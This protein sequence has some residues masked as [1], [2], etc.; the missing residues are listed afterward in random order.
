MNS[1]EL[2]Q[3]I[4]EYTRGVQVVPAGTELALR[5]G[6]P[7]VYR[8]MTKESADGPDVIQGDD[9]SWTPAA[10]QGG[11]AYVDLMRTEGDAS[12][13]V[14]R[15]WCA[16]A[17]WGGQERWLVYARDGQIALRPTESGSTRLSIVGRGPAFPEDGTY[18]TA[19]CVYQT[20]E[21][22]SPSPL[23]A[24]LLQFRD[25]AVKYWAGIR[26]TPTGQLTTALDRRS[27]VSIPSGRSEC[28]PGGMGQPVPGGV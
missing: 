16:R 9:F 19:E 21:M 1:E 26:R 24:E 11:M 28:Q 3:T 2:L 4:L 23:S 12:G 22:P 15:I 27:T 5:M 10:W 25:E 17:R 8:M 6:L 13:S 14:G 20:P 18:L 7:G